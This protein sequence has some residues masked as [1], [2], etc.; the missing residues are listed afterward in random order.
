M[1]RLA[2]VVVDLGAEEDD[3]LLEQAVVDV[4]PLEGGAVLLRGRREEV[5]L[6]HVSQATG[7]AAG[8]RPHGCDAGY[9]L[10]R[11]VRAWRELADAPG[12]G[13][14]G[15]IREGSS[16]SARTPRGERSARSPRQ[17][18]RLD[19]LRGGDGA[20]D[21]ERHRRQRRDRLIRRARPRDGRRIAVDGLAD[22]DRAS[23]D[24]KCGNG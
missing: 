10:D 17:R 21:L 14:G 20:A 5:A 7:D 22:L 12:L 8:Y 19:D 3:A 4:H 16:P 15:A 6:I 24:A 11:T 13:P 2:I 23:V 1:I 9:G 18:R